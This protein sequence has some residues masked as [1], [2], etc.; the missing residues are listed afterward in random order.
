ME[1][2]I[3]YGATTSGGTIVGHA[4]DEKETPFLYAG[5]ASGS[6]TTANQKMCNPLA[7]YPS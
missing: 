2:L 6:C 7:P 4:T 5:T 1:G 3:P